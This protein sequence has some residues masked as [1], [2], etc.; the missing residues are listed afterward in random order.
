[1]QTNDQENKDT[2]VKFT[3]LWPFYNIVDSLQA[4]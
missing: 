1:M 2:Y 4:V 3:V